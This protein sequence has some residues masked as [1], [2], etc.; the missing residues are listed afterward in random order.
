V[1]VVGEPE[2]ARE[3]AGITGPQPPVGA[4]A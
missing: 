4:T 2:R 1:I 3:A